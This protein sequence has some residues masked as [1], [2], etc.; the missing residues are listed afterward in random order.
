M[1]GP[2]CAYICA[3]VYSALQRSR[4]LPATAERGPEV[5]RG[6]IKWLRP[7]PPSCSS[8]RVR[9]QPLSHWMRKPC[10]PL[11]CYPTHRPT[12]PNLAFQPWLGAVGLCASTGSRLGCCHGSSGPGISGA[13]VPGHSPVQC[14][15][16][17][18]PGEAVQCK[19]L[20][21]PRWELLQRI[22]GTTRSCQQRLELLFLL[23]ASR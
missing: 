19:R 16:S 9:T 6:C 8:H 1:T 15:L 3:E 21:E 10:K 12:G 17:H 13:S 7:L 2:G 23:P 4:W 20:P 5:R 22:S 14:V 11:Q 18:L